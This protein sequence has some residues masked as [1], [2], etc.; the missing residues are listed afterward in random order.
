MTNPSQLTNNDIVNAL[1]GKSTDEAIEQIYRVTPVGSIDSAIGNTLSTYN[2]RQQP[3]LVPINRDNHGYTFFTRPNLNLTT[4]NLAYNRFWSPMLTT[5]RRSL[6]RYIRNTLDPWLSYKEEGISSDFVDDLSPFIPLLSNNLI[7]ISGWPD[8]SVES[9]VSPDGIYKETVGFVDSLAT[10]YTS[11]S[12][13]ANFRNLVGDPISFMIFYWMFYSSMV[14]LNKVSPYPVNAI[15]DCVDYQTR[16]YRLVMDPTKRY[17]QKIAA[18]GACYPTSVPLG[19]A[20]D[21]NSEQPLNVANEQL[22]ITFQA[23]GF[24]VLD[25]ILIDEFNRSTYAFNKS[26]M[27]ASRGRYYTKI[28]YQLLDFFNNRGNPIINEDTYELEWWLDNATFNEVLQTITPVAKAR[29][30]IN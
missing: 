21:F 4:P 29:G 6:P 16:I 12:I 5:N 11:Y 2:H 7:S 23:F 9:Y 30:N 8:P 22:S 20:F 26:M 18:C 15:E 25:T 13:T 1:S 10:N 24:I 27:P 3:G 28:P 17:V 19:S 14:Y